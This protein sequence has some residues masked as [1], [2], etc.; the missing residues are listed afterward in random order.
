MSYCHIEF[1]NVIVMITAAA[2]KH[3]QEQ[4]YGK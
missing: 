1:M 2:C 3:D 4:C